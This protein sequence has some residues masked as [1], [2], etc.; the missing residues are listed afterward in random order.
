MLRVVE[1]TLLVHLVFLFVGK[2]LVVLGRTSAVGLCG[3]CMGEEACDLM[4]IM[5]VLPAMKLC[6]WWLKAVSFRCSFR[7]TNLGTYWL[8]CEGMTFGTQE[9][10]VSDV[11]VCFVMK[12]VMC[13]VGV[14]RWLLLRCC[15]SLL[16]RRRNPSLVS[17]FYL[18]CR[19]LKLVGCILAISFEPVQG[20][21][22]LSGDT[23][24]I[25]D[26]VVLAT[27]GMTN[28]LGYT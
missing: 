1:T 10:S 8:S 26:R 25:I 12:L 18:V 4:L 27:V 16:N 17:L 13:R 20:D 19:R 7:V 21:A 3:T 11:S 2:S 5:M 14:T 24:P 15:V 6:T 23:L 22:W 28:L 9:A